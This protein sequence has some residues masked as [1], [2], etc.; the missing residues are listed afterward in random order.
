MDFAVPRAIRIDDGLPFVGRTTY[1]G[2]SEL[3][4]WLVLRR[5]NGQIEYLLRAAVAERSYKPPKGK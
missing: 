5:V 3:S 4:V 2:L 1:F